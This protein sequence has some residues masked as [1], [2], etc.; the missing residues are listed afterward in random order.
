MKDVSQSDFLRL[1]KRIETL[2]DL[3]SGLGSWRFYH[4]V[5]QLGL[6]SG[7]SIAQVC[8]AMPDRSIAVLNSGELATASRAYSEFDTI[9]IVRQSG[10][11]C[12]IRCTGT[13]GYFW[14]GNWRMSD[15]FTGWKAMPVKEEG[16][17]TPAFYGATTAGSYSYS[18]RSGIYSRTDD[19]VFIR[20]HM[21]FTINSLPSGAFMV[22][23]LPFVT[24]SWDE[25]LLLSDTNGGNS[26][27]MR[28]CIAAQCASGSAAA[29]LMCLDNMQKW[30]AST[31]RVS[32]SVGNTVHI[33]LSGTH[34]IH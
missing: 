21:D 1:A 26:D 11:R 14:T 27:S 16:T 17:F 22:G 15:G 25:A 34:L 3:K 12:A 18:S 19:L 20:L 7:A 32:L 24:R 6:S 23:G 10:Y 8:A 28:Q 9:E 31:S 13:N 4:S 29:V 30:A 5:A 33:S 2:H